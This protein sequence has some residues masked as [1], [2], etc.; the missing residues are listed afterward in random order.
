M[1]WV[2]GASCSQTSPLAPAGT[3]RAGGDGASA[4]PARTGDTSLGLC[5]LQPHLQVPACP[6][7]PTPSLS[8]KCPGL[9]P[10]QTC[11]GAPGPFF[12]LA[13]QKHSLMLSLPPSSPLIPTSGPP[14]PTLLCPGTPGSAFMH[15]QV[16]RTPHTSHWIGL[17]LSPAPA[18]W[19]VPL[20]SHRALPSMWPQ[21]QLQQKVSG[22]RRQRG[23]DGMAAA[24]HGEEPGAPSAFSS[25]VLQGSTGFSTVPKSPLEETEAAMV[26]G[27]R[28][29][30]V[31]SRRAPAPTPTHAACLLS[32]QP[33]KC[34]GTSASTGLLQRHFTEGKLR[35]KVLHRHQVTQLSGRAEI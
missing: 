12:L 31:H 2:A 30:A 11:Q 1:W 8:P 15:T 3:G 17:P 20:G 14:V 28:T 5:R 24:P 34:L 23:K 26:A 33:C 4:E 13:S 9:W 16:L 10:A 21:P 35:H 32:T 27:P 29:T 25:E 7:L 6:S 22:S 19:Q 18:T